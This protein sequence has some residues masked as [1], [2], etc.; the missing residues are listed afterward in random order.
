MVIYNASC[1]CRKCSVVADHAHVQLQSSPTACTKK[2]C[3]NG[4]LK[5]L[6]LNT[7]LIHAYCSGTLHFT[8]FPET[9]L[10][11][12][13]G[14]SLVTIN[15]SNCRGAIAALEIAPLRRSSPRRPFYTLSIYRQQTFL[16]TDASG[17]EGWSLQARFTSDANS[18]EN[19]TGNSACARLTSSWSVRTFCFWHFAPSTVAGIDIHLFIY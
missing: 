1:R 14:L 18:S 7:R 15:G 17:A 2:P 4:V 19:S 5:S 16:L 9:Q 6:R 3:T 10:L 13:C 12:V 8:S 11:I